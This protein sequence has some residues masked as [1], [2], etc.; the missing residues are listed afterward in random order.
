MKNDSP[1][2]TT[3]PEQRLGVHQFRLQPLPRIDIRPGNIVH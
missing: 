2:R 3:T 1:E